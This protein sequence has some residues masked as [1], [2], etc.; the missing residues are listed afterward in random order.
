MV[1]LWWEWNIS[2]TL[3]SC[4]VFTILVAS[5]SLPRFLMSGSRRISSPD[6]PLFYHHSFSESRPV[7]LSAWPTSAGLELSVQTNSSSRIKWVWQ[8][9][10]NLL[11]STNKT[12]LSLFQTSP[13]HTPSFLFQPLSSL[14]QPMSSLCHTP[15][16]SSSPCPPPSTPPLLPLPH[17][18]L[19]LPLL[20]PS[21]VFPLPDAADA[22]QPVHARQDV[23][24]ARGGCGDARLPHRGRP[25]AAEDG[26]RVRP[27]HR[28]ARWL[29]QVPRT[30]THRLSDAHQEGKRMTAGR[31]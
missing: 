2:V 1:F 4:R 25:D 7:L 9:D 10:S 6:V 27:R 8:P 18:L 12:P 24:G 17:P 16:P 31:C 26:G 19:P 23:G 22:H 14:F 30:P 28:D 20:Q 5:R 29:L 3:V 15:L 11:F 13:F 21:P